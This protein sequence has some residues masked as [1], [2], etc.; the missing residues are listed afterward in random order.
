MK[1]IYER[2]ESLLG[3][4]AR[5][6][7]LF[8]IAL[9]SVL[10]FDLI[11]RSLSLNAHYTDQG[12]VSRHVL[13]GLSDNPLLLSLN[14]LSGDPLWQWLLFFLAACFAICLILGYRSQLACFGCLVLMLSIHVRNPFVNN[15]G[16][17]F[18]LH[19][20]FWGCLLP[21]GAR[22][23][24]DARR[25]RTLGQL[26]GQILS[27]ATLGILVQIAA[28]YFFSVFKKNSPVWHTE[29]T[30]V[31][32]ALRLDRFVTDIGEWVLSLPYDWL[33][34]IT[35]ATLFL[36]QWGPILLFVPFFIAPIR[37]ALVSCFILFHTGLALT[38]ELGIFPF[39]CM[40][41]WLLVIPGSFW[42]RLIAFRYRTPRQPRRTYAKKAEQEVSLSF[43][44][45]TLL[46]TFMLLIMISG[47]LLHIEKMSVAYYEGL[48]K[49]GEPL[50]NSLNLQQRWSMFS[51]HP[52]RQ[53]GWVVLAGVK[54]DGTM[55]DL[56]KEGQLVSWE[57]PEDISALYRNQR[58]RKN[59][60][61]VTTKWDRHARLLGAYSLRQWNATQ[62]EKVIEVLVYFMSELEVGPEESS[63]V[64]KKLLY[65]AEYN[66]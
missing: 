18:L 14:M 23:S 26:P 39:V 30:A 10:L 45:S 58:W 44:A 5:S 35:S 28:L 42:D 56:W 60:E 40:S 3:V 13:K 64:S 66:H 33:T 12:I 57:R 47:N 59:L 1:N 17:W 38:L 4:D 16:D 36:E 29:G 63:Q 43:V 9:G 2:V 34:T 7:G 53:D 8:R 32:F 21:L 31:H 65:S 27:V 24:I 62:E 48:Y 6:L 20:L 41:A 49:Y 22:F 46:A 11:V 55:I 50:I 15:L 52:S 61:Y 51:P 54:E 37:L 25:R 19:L